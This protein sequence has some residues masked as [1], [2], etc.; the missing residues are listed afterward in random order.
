MLKGWLIPFQIANSIKMKIK[1][2]YFP[3][4]YFE[5]YYGAL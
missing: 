1:L 4:T 5:Q 3:P 2:Y